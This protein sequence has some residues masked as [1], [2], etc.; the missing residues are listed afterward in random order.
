[1][2]IS[3]STPGRFGAFGN[4]SDPA[5]PPW[6]NLSLDDK[7]AVVASFIRKNDKKAYAHVDDNKLENHIRFSIYTNQIYLIFDADTDEIVAVATW[8]VLPKEQS[9]FLVGIIGD[10][11]FLRY[12]ISLWHQTFPFYDLRYFRNGRTVQRKNTKIL[13]NN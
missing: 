7:I 3:G 13:I 6:I 1:M 5:D 2:A 8:N 11:Q 12:M 9:V 4:S 10:K